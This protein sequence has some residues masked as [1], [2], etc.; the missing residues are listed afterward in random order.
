MTKGYFKSAPRENLLEHLEDILK[1]I[2]LR[3]MSDPKQSRFIQ[4]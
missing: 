1:V 4:F 3:Q 2:S